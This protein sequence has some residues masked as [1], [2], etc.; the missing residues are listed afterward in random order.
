M[1]SSAAGASVLAM[2]GGLA[3]LGPA[4]LGSLVQ[5]CSRGSRS[6]PRIEE[7]A[8]RHLPHL[9]L[10]LQLLHSISQA[11]K[12]SLGLSGGKIDPTA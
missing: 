10:P 7:E 6:V 3:P 2:S 8:A 1:A 5:T 11:C 4:S 9:P 12:T